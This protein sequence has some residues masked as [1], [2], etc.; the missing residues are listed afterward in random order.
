MRENGT[1][2]LPAVAC[3][4]VIVRQSREIIASILADP[5]PGLAHIQQRLRRWVA[6]Y[7]GVPDRALLAHMIETSRQTNRQ[8]REPTA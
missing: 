5:D 2:P 3:E 7:P 1:Q 4:A 6:A 8:T